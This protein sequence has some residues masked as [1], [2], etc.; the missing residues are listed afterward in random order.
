MHLDGDLTAFRETLV[1][2][3]ALGFF[4]TIPAAVGYLVLAFPL[5]HAISF[6]RMDGAG[7]GPMVA[8]SL[9]GLSVA[10]VGQTAFM[11]ATYASYA[12]KDTRSPLISMLLQAVACLALVSAALLAH[13]PTVLLLLGLAL[14]VAVAVAACHLT[15]RVWRGLGRRDTQ[16]LRG[17][18]RLAPSVLKFAA[19]SGIMAGPPRLTATPVSPLGGPPL[20]PRG[21]VLA[22]APLCLS[23]F[24]CLGAPV[25]CPPTGCVLTRRSRSSS[26]PRSRRGV[27]C[28][29]APASCRRSAWTG[30]K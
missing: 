4:I 5:A 19:G 10:V 21:A 30:W 12:R 18:Q 25:P 23:G 26:E 11:I 28:G 20:R 14:S 15:A 2:G 7:G 6:G 22:A 17:T 16:R 13:G 8:V 1:R 24:L 27:W 9:A 29:S 3:F